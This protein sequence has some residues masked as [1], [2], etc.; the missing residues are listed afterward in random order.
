MPYL[1]TTSRTTAK[2][3]RL[4]YKPA[5][6]H[7]R[8]W[9]SFPPLLHLIRIDHLLYMVV[10]APSPPTMTASASGPRR[11]AVLS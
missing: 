8:H 7:P 4:A 6:P 5:A 3:L 9:W 1:T 2:G 11:S 10:G